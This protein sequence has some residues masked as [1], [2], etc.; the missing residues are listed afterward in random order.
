MYSHFVIEIEA[1]S[2]KWHLF[3][4]EC[5]LKGAFTPNQFGFV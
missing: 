1:K 5:R 4:S 2:V 3:V